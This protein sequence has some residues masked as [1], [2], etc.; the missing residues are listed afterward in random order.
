MVDDVQDVIDAL[1]AVGRAEAVA[2]LTPNPFPFGKL[3]AGFK[4]KGH[5][6]I[7]DSGRV[8]ISTVVEK[9]VE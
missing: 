4:G 1:E 2:D 5:F 6:V 7:A 3:R 8:R 9:R